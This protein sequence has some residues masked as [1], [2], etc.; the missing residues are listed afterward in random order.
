MITN[1]HSTKLPREAA[2]MTLQIGRVL[3]QLCV[4]KIKFL[5]EF[6]NHNEGVLVKPPSFFVQVSEQLQIFLAD[7]RVHW[8][9]SF[10]VNEVL[11]PLFTQRLE[12]VAN[13]FQSFR[14]D[15][16]AHPTTDVTFL[17]GLRQ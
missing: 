11:V 3:S 12:F 17:L 16:D 2:A 8:L 1:G 15:N 7:V 10:K 6:V 14:G 5:F 13:T 9:N 4:R